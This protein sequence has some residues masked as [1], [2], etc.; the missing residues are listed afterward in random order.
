MKTAWKNAALSGAFL[1]IS[2]LI[3]GQPPAP[4]RGPGMPPAPY[5]SLQEVSSVSG[6]VVKLAANDDFVYDGFYIIN[7]GDSLLVKFPPH[8]GAQITRA[9]AVGTNVTVK[10]VQQV[11]PEGRKEMH[12]VSLMA[13][14]QSYM[15]SPPTAMPAPQA[16]EAISGSGKITAVQ[17]GAMGE[18]R[19]L[20]IDGKTILH[21]P[22]HVAAQ[23]SSALQPGSQISYTGNKKA[24]NS[25][26]AMSGSYTI[27]RTTTLTVNGKQY[28]VQ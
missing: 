26:E 13:G 3:F 19:G 18:A 7:S 15:D 6:K 4:R 17:T 14:G 25:G 12:M 28:L 16:E 22:P 10:G 9:A 1:T 24:V 5:M 8:M 27:V 23:L 11:S 20:V 21:V 2:A